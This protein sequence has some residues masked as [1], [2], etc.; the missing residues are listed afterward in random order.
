MQRANIVIK[1]PR[2]GRE[3][4]YIDLEVIMTQTATAVAPTHEATAESDSSLEALYTAAEAFGHQSVAK[5]A[6]DWVLTS[7][8]PATDGLLSMPDGDLQLT[9]TSYEIF[10]MMVPHGQESAP[11]SVHALFEAE[12]GRRYG[13][14]VVLTHFDDRDGNCFVEVEVRR[15]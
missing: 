14:P 9:T 11:G 5:A 12:L 7:V 10:A 13:F 6:V 3:P 8:G 1:Y 4:E 15:A 2:A